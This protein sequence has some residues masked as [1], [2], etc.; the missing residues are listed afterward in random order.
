[1]VVA[2]V[3]VDEGVLGVDPG[4]TPVVGDG[5]L[6]EEV[7]VGRNVLLQRDRVG[8]EVAMEDSK[9][10]GHAPNAT[11]PMDVKR[12]E[13][14]NPLIC[15]EIGK[16]FDGDMVQMRQRR[17]GASVCAIRHGARNLLRHAAN[18]PIMETIFR[19]TLQGQIVR[20][21]TASPEV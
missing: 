21:G 13:R 17:K 4:A 14:L 2:T 12:E 19:I 3:L 18:C 7:V 11:P 1:M 9:R 5:G 16:V 10:Q 8:P 6:G 20:I 15:Q